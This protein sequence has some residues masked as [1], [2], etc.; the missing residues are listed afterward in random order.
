MQEKCKAKLERDGAIVAYMP[1]DSK[2]GFKKVR[3]V[4]SDELNFYIPE[5]WDYDQ[6]I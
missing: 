5:K 4:K 1:Y 2:K 6:I 3:T